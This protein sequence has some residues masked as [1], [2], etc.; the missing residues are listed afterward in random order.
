MKYFL[1]GIY[2]R[3]VPNTDDY[4]KVIRLFQGHP[5]WTPINRDEKETEIETSHVRINYL[6]SIK[7]E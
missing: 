2:H 1:A 5:V 3:F 7:S 6:N 4:I